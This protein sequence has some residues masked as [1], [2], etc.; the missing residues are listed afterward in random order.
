M[1][2]NNIAFVTG[3]YSGEAVISYKSAITIENN[4]DK[5]RYKSSRSTLLLTAGGMKTMGGKPRWTEK[6]SPSTR[7]QRK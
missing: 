6:I 5:E 4:L 3:G 2:G 1:P 7:Q